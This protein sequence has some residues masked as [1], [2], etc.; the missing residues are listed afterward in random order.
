MS[1]N[2]MTYE[3]AQCRRQAVDFAGQPEAAFLLR[4]ASTFDELAKRAAP[5]LEATDGPTDAPPRPVVRVSPNGSAGSLVR[6]R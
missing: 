4:V 1:A 3:A 6:T 2:S 5:L